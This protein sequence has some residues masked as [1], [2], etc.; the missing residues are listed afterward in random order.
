V[1]WSLF[2][3][4]TLSPADAACLVYY[5][6]KILAQGFSPSFYSSPGY[7]THAS[8]LKPWVMNHPGERAQ[9]IWTSALYYKTNY[10]VNIS[11]AVIYNEPTLAGSLLMDDIKAL[12]LRLSAYGLET[13]VQ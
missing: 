11:Y 6:D 2:E 4:D 8:D 13:K 12:G 3:A 7:P 5:R 9:Q 10:G 1:D